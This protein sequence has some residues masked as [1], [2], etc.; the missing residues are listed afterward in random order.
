MIVNVLEYGAD[1]TGQKDSAPA[2][3][4]AIDAC[5]ETGGQVYFPAGRFLSGCLTL[6][7]QVELYLEQGAVL[8]SD[9]T[10]EISPYFLYACHEK[11]IAISGHGIIDGQGRLRFFEDGADGGYEECPLNVSGRRPRTSFFEDIENLTVTGITFYDAAF[12]TLH[13][14]GCRNVRIDGIRIL[15]HDRG[16]NNDGIDP[17][18]C[19]NVLIQNCIIESG[20]DNIVVK[21]TKEMHEKYGDCEDIIIRG[22]VLHSRDS[23][24][25]IGTETW[26]NIRNVLFSDC[27]V[28]DCS[29][30]IGIWSRD[31]GEISDIHI[32]HITGNTRRYADCPDR[33]FAP[34]WWGKG[35]PV[36]LSATKRKDSSQTPGRISRIFLD[37]V[38]LTAESCMFLGGEEDAPVEQIRMRDMDICWK[39]QSLHQP[40]VFDEQ[41]SVRDVYE[42]EVPCIYGRFANQV[43]INGRF[44]VDPSMKESIKKLAMTEN[45]KNFVIEQEEKHE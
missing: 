4:K 36:F 37:H 42:H 24:L 26:G 28:K 45:C 7:S 12:W 16:P 39:Q 19:Q 41:P 2:I 31:G 34:R 3:Q 33:E 25:K 14:A 27:I 1:G 22:C 32:H 10:N 5:S 20:D 15:N 21:A 43:Q 40:D 38:C 18:C 23:A 11:N 8:V 17:D 6:R 44:F 35:E 29:R 30:A 13:M 9:L